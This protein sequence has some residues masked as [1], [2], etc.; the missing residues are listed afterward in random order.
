MKKDEC[1]VWSAAEQ[2]SSSFG[3]D[4]IR[5]SPYSCLESAFVAGANWQKEE[6]QWKPSDKQMDCLKSLYKELEQ[7]IN[8]Y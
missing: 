8:E 5:M 7:L 3:I 4:E 1:D 2:Y 6:C